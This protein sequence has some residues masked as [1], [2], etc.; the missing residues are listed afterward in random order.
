[1]Q[2]PTYSKPTE[3][4]ELENSLLYR[5]QVESDRNCKNL[6]DIFGINH[7]EQSKQQQQQ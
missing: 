1:M 3:W 2:K 6:A 5:N 7:C 4:K